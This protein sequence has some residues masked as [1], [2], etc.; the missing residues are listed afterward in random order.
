MS[1]FT[2]KL[3]QV[4]QRRQ[5]KIIL[6]DNKSQ[7]WIAT[8]LLKLIWYEGLELKVFY[9]FTYAPYIILYCMYVN[10]WNN[11][12]S[13]SSYQI[14][15]SKMEHVV[16]T[17]FS[18]AETRSTQYKPLYHTEENSILLRFIGIGII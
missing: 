16:V 9:L 12:S 8:I 15:S 11:F 7:Q 2:Y 4:V 1:C 17:I 5:N 14:N 18:R 3:Y 6:D 13:S 10:R